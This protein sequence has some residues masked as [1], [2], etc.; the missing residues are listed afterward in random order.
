MKIALTG[1]ARS[2]KDTVK[3]YLVDKYG[4]VPFAFADELKVDFHEEYPNIPA[5]PKPVQGY[6]LYGQ[7]MRYVHG[8]DYWIDKC[9]YKINYIEE[10]AKQLI[11]MSN[12]DYKNVVHK[13]MPV[14]SDIRQDNEV[15]RCKEEGFVLI[16]VSCPEDVRW[17][18]MRLEGD[19]VTKEDLHFVTEKS[20][21][22]F[23]VDYEIDNSGTL[24]EL[25][26]QVDNIVKEIM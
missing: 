14:I 18:R 12:K 17:E 20:V 10:I 23:T 8:E 16:R 3:D 1:K 26:Y 7:L 19:S 5:Y 11:S 2:G 9:F 25:W 15:K 13:Y 21:D 4:A 6:Q 22:D 24:D